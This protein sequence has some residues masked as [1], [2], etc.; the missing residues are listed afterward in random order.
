MPT[1]IPVRFVAARP[2]VP[3]VVTGTPSWRGNSLAPYVALPAPTGTQAFVTRGGGRF[4]LVDPRTGPFVSAQRGTIDIW[5]RAGT[6]AA[7]LLLLQSAYATSSPPLS[8]LG[9]NGSGQAVGSFHDA[10]G[11]TIATWAATGMPSVAPGTINRLTLAWDSAR[12]ISGTH[13][14][15]V[16]ANGVP[17]PA[18]A[19]STLPLAPWTPFQ[20]LYLAT[21]VGTETDFDGEILL[22]R[23]SPSVSL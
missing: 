7:T 1:R 10:K 4:N 16:L 3:T 12:A 18:S 20:P 13:H 14:V 5:Y 8:T 15:A 19:F 22:T 23:A 21:G 6:K 2:G 17:M 9:V 11:V